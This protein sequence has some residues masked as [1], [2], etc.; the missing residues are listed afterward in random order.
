[1]ATDDKHPKRLFTWLR[2]ANVRWY[3]LAVLAVILLALLPGLSDAAPSVE[4]RS[5]DLQNVRLDLRTQWQTQR[6]KTTNAPQLKALD[7]S[8]VWDWP[9]SQF[10]AGLD[11]KAVKLELGERLVSRLALQTKADAQG[12]VLDLPMPRLDAAH[13]SYRYN[14]EPWVHA[15]AGDQI[16]MVQWPF[17]HRS[18]AFFLP[19]KSGELQL[20]LEIG[21]QGLMTSPVLLVSDK[22]FRA[23]RFDAALRTGVLLGLAV[24]LSLVGFGAAAVFGRFSFMAVALLVVTVGLAVFTQDGVAG[25]YLGTETSR[26]NDVSKF[27][28]GML[29]G[30]FLPWAVATVLSQKFYSLLVWRATIIWLVLGLLGVLLMT[31]AGSR[32][33]QGL[34]LP[35]YLLISL[36][37]AIGMAVVSVVR[38][39]AYALWTLVAVM[40][41][42]LGI[43]APLFS[44]WGWMDGPQSLTLSSVGFLVSTLLLFYAQLLQYRHGRLVMTRATQSD[45]RDALTGLLNRAGFEKLLRREVK[46]ITADRS[47]AAFYYIEVGDVAQ[48]QERYGGEGFET[49]LLQIAAA[50]SSSVSVVDTVARIAPNALV[51]TVVMQRNAAAANALA[52]KIISRT[53]AMAS[54][55]VPMAQNSRIAI[56]WLPTFGTELHDIERRALTVLRKMEMGKRIAWV[57]GSQA[58]VDPGTIAD[59]GLS[60][61][62]SMPGSDHSSSDELPSLPG[63]IN[64]IEHE[65][66]GLDQPAQSNAEQ[67][68]RVLRNL[69]PITD[70]R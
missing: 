6:T 28:S 12:L 56:A 67:P 40:F 37:F 24:V 44:Y 31:G 1:M 36:L 7:P 66:L 9:D 65:M 42:C 50:V 14:G 51:V 13:L 26:F 60:T 70:E 46:R 45:G 17:F 47:Q 19:A 48:L 29:C 49:G 58:Q 69:K 11:L 55:S 25:M 43:N 23:E 33:G 39:Q 3:V 18:P 61:L 8:V 16:P 22:L 38:Q 41:V 62:G 21:H 4:L 64:R 32:V 2:S 34:L 53:M 27:I 52:Q 15:M 68:M 30:A 10:N 57:G 59:G 54:H 20:V 5:Q 35:P 63:I